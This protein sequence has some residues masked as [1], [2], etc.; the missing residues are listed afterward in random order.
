[1]LKTTVC[2]HHTDRM[3]KINEAE[4]STTCVRSCRMTGIQR[5]IPPLEALGISTGMDVDRSS[6]QGTSRRLTGF[7][8][9]FWFRV[10]QVV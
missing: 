8:F 1:M 4:T 7:W 6:R 9:W 10:L 2:V 5:G 3:G